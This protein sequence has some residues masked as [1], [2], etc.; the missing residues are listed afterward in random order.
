VRAGAPVEGSLVRKIEA[1]GQA[2]APAE[3]AE[4]DLLLSVALARGV[5]QADR[6]LG[7][8]EAAPDGS[9]L[10]LEALDEAE[11]AGED[12]GRWLDTHMPKDPVYWGLAWALLYYQDIA[13]K[14]GW[15]KMALGPKLVPGQRDPRV[16]LLRTRLVA[17]G[18]AAPGA[19]ADPELYDPALEQA[20]LRF[21]ERHGLD[22]DG[23]VGA[24]TQDALNVM[25]E[26]RVAQILLNLE[27][28]RADGHEIGE[29]YVFVN[30]PAS[31]VEVHEGGR[32]I[33]R[34]K[35]IVGRID[36]Q[37][38]E[39]KSV[40][41][42]VV[43]NPFW[44]VPVSIVSRDLVAKG[45]K[46][47]GYFAARKIRV[48][49]SYSETASE[50]DPT[51]V[52]WYSTEAKRLRMRQD[53]GPDNALGPIKFDFDNK[54]SVYL[55]GTSTPE[56]FEKYERLLSSGCVRVAQP[57]DLAAVLFAGAPGYDRAGLDAIVADGKTTKVSIPNPWPLHIAYRT[58]WVDPAGIVHFRPDP[59]GRDKPLRA[60]QVAAKK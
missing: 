3:L 4:L 36:R 9:P 49:A 18:D 50:I 8:A 44:Y 46:D 19:V 32:V 31:E 39:L 7:V 23:V 38:P 15:E 40:I 12:I 60:P 1:L 51:S 28:V 2:A 35:V 47:P 56:L 54:Y 24:K 41:D 13:A 29:R 57:L 43:L 42:R 37:T 48:F 30:I 45:Q 20:V 55:H 33:F 11:D 34:S 14:G 10:T 22:P 58:A 21:Q 25:V 17:S 59:Y 27:R 52:N 53:P 26:T 5:Y 6:A 16:A